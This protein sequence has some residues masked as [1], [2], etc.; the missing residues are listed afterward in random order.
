MMLDYVRF[1]EDAK[2]RD[3]VLVPYA[4]EVLTFFDEHF[5]RGPDGKLRLDPS[6]VLETWWVAVNSTPDV[7]GLRVCLDGLLA[8]KAG[9]SGDQS[10]WKKL[11][12]EIPEIPMQTID[13]RQA[14][15]PAESWSNKRNAENG[16]LYPVFPFP[17]FGVA[18]GNAGIVEWT[19]QHRTSKGDFDGR[20]WTQEQIDWACAGNAMEAASGL[21]HRFR[22]ASP[23]HRFPLYGRE[24]PD[25]A[26]DFDHF[27][28]GSVALQRML[29]QEAGEKIFLLPAWPADWDADFKLYLS[30]ETV[31]TGSV[32]DGKL[33]SWD[34][35]PVSR[36]GD[37]I[38]GKPQPGKSP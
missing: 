21:V 36:R 30:H 23:S 38:L 18:L 26:P 37:V 20:C 6:Q 15:A 13:G 10:R 12:M 8:L 14:I 7:A 29:V 28:S 35:H 16:E 1:T 2:F 4:R 17:C 11:R 32:K 24:N 3:Q 25:A 33:V 27:G 9:T 31:L 22:I 34:V 5:G 19:M